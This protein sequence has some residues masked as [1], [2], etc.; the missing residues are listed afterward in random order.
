MKFTRNPSDFDIVTSGTGDDESK[1]EKISEPEEEEEIEEFNLPKPREIEIMYSRSMMELL[2]VNGDE[3]RGSQNNT[4]VEPINVFDESDDDTPSETSLEFE[5]KLFSS[6]M[7]TTFWA[8][9]KTGITNIH[10]TE[11]IKDVTISLN[12]NVGSDGQLCFTTKRELYRKS[13][14]DVSS[15]REGALQDVEEFVFGDSDKVVENGRVTYVR[16]NPELR[17]IK[18]LLQDLSPRKTNIEPEVRQN[19]K[20]I[21]NSQNTPKPPP[22]ITNVTEMNEMIMEISNVLYLAWEEYANDCVTGLFPILEPS[23]MNMRQYIIL[24]GV[25]QFDFFEREPQPFVNKEY[26]KVQLH[27]GEYKLKK[28][29][30]DRISDI[31]P[32]LEEEAERVSESKSM[33]SISQR[34]SKLIDSFILET[35]RESEFYK[36]DYNLVLLEVK[37][38]ENLIFFEA[39]TP[40]RWNETDKYWTTDETYDTTWDPDNRIVQFKLGKTGPFALAAFRFSNL[41][42]HSFRLKPSIDWKNDPVVTLELETRFFPVTF[43]VKEDKITITKLEHEDTPLISHIIGVPFTVYDLIIAMRNAGIDIFPEWDSFLYLEKCFRRL[44]SLEEHAY[45][46]IGVSCPAF[47]FTESSYNG[48]AGVNKIYFRMRE[49]IDKNT[50]EQYRTLSASPFNVST[51]VTGESGTVKEDPDNLGAGYAPDLKYLAEAIAS[52]NAFRRMK[53]S[54]KCT[55]ATVI[56]LISSTKIL[57]YS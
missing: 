4:K 50:P 19:V 55:I 32:D 21:P 25:Y 30:F 16:R 27:Y 56:K 28:V 29:V 51:V 44:K 34:F 37:V 1:I 18:E 23:E 22:K 3:C 26:F 54:S 45:Y 35:K 41:P 57:S 20:D 14:R 53:K 36:P 46:S 7:H 13:Y 10:D 33:T 43:V 47:E 48:T 8:C 42:Y 11:N 15:D 31:R 24:G 6:E 17:S 9:F 2:E 40:A 12:D 52:K 49:G 5:R 38:P 39:P